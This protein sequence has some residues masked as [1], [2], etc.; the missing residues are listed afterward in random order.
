MG[1]RR[2]SIYTHPCYVRVISYQTHGLTN[3]P[4]ALV[5]LFICKV[6]EEIR[7]IATQPTFHIRLESWGSLQIF[8]GSGILHMYDTGRLGGRHSV[9]LQLS[10]YNQI[11]SH[12]ES[13]GVLAFILG[14]PGA[15]TAKTPTPRLY[16]P[17]PRDLSI[18]GVIRAWQWAHSRAPRSLYRAELGTI[19]RNQYTAFMII[20]QKSAYTTCIV[21]PVHA[22]TW[23][24]GYYP[25]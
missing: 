12:K 6:G 22:V 4:N 20:W 23:F 24:S 18:C 11:S 7:I 9:K 14:F 13:Q 15:Q 16:S 10:R 3:L 21:C 17:I 25:T 5:P 2:Q 8:L 1:Q 19:G